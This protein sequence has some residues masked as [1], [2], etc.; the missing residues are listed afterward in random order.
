MDPNSFSWQT[1]DGLKLVGYTWKTFKKEKAIISLVHGAGEHALRYQHLADFFIN[2]GISITSFDLRGH[3]KSEGLRGHAISYDIICKDIDSI[4]DKTKKLSPNSPLFIYGHSLGG[5][6]AL[7]YLI[8]RRQD[9]QGAIISA[10]LLRSGT[11]V[12]PLKMLAAKLMNR[13]L[14]TFTLP[15]GLD[16]SG[17][18]RDPQVQKLYSKDPLVHDR[19]SARLGMEILDK[20]I[21]ILNHVQEL[22]IPILLMQGSADRIVDV[23]KTIE[24]SNKLPPSSTFILWKNFYHELHNEPEKREVLQYELDWITKHL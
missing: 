20:G 11:P 3:G 4:I 21:Y 12:P 24:L 13:V 2:A 16:Q 15:N 22:K 19:I 7:Y 9:F 6:L 14:P 10:P 5:E 23:Q 18:S 17:L 1:S 8:H